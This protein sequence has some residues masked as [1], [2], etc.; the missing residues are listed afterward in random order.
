MDL[1]YRLNVIPVHIPP[2]RE[3]VED[4]VPIASG[5][6]EKLNHKNGTY[7]HFSWEVQNFIMQYPWPGN[8]RE[9]GNIVERLYVFSPKELILPSYLPDELLQ[10]VKPGSTAQHDDMTLR[11]I[12]ETVERDTILRYL[13]SKMTLNEIALKLDISISTLVRKI[14]KYNLRQNQINTVSL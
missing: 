13:K 10:Y 6:L 4:I 11:D 1:Y 14:Q 8:I 7:K 9:L 2:L 3:R 12:T 5:I